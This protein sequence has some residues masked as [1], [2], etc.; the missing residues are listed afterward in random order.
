HPAALELGAE[1]RIALG[2]RAGDPVPYGRG[3]ARDPAA[4]DAYPDVDAALVAGLRERL[5]GD[6]LQ[7]GTREVLLELALV[8]LD[9]A[10][11]GTKDHAGDR[12]LAL[13]GGG[14]GGITRELGRLGGEWS[15]LLVLIA[16]Q[17]ALPTLALLLLRFASGALL[18]V[19]LALGLDRNRVELGTGYDVLSLLRRA[20]LP[21]R[22]LGRSLLVSR[23]DGLPGL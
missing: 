15:R 3:L 22:L 21:S 11:A 23:S 17:L 18:G 1:R 2:E 10:A 6:R 7:V 16:D 5:L 4:M 12:G 19:E 20:V 9:A 14:V 8:H 13:A